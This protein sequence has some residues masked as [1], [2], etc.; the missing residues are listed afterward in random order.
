VTSTSPVMVSPGRTGAVNFHATSRKTVPGPGS[1]SAT[2]AFRMALVMP[3]WTM[4]SPKRDAPA[5]S[6]S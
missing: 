4:I 3:P 1:S 5:A 6:A 2:T